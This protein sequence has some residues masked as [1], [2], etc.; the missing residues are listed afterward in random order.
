MRK[1]TLQQTTVFAFARRADLFVSRHTADLL[2]DLLMFKK[3]LQRKLKDEEF[4]RSL[5]DYG[6]VGV[7][8]LAAG[9]LFSLV[10]SLLV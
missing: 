8:T 6:I 1:S 10:A 4:R 2:T 3:A 9:A 7:T 5:L